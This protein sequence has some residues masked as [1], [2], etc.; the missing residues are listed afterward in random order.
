MTVRRK[1][2]VLTDE[3]KGSLWINPD[4]E[5]WAW[6][7]HD[8]RML[9]SSGLWSG[10]LL[11]SGESQM[12]AAG[13]FV[14]VDFVEVEERPNSPC[15]CCAGTDELHSLTVAPSVIRRDTS[16]GPMEARSKMI[17]QPNEDREHIPSADCWCKPKVE[18]VPPLELAPVDETVGPLDEYRGQ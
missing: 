17:D 1:P 4:G 5:V 18:Y 2:D 15:P 3:H 13:P 14:E 8:W 6:V 12:R 10:V 11:Y 7:Q 9:R 16:V